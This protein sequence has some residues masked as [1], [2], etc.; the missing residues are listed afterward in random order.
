ML[1]RSRSRCARANPT[2]RGGVR[3][4]PAGVALLR[5]A[6][7]DDDKADPTETWVADDLGTDVAATA[8]SG[9][10]GLTI[11]DLSPPRLGL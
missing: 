10:P 8:V 3:A 4:T 5:V 11:G 2:D 1:F 7:S 9:E 6:P